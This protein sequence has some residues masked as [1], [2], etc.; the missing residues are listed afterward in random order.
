MPR[1][2]TQKVAIVVVAIVIVVS[3]SSSN[4]T[5]WLKNVKLLCLVARNVKN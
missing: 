1:K 3:S 4:T 2:T 5:R